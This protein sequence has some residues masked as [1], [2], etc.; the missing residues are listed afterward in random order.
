MLSTVGKKFSRQHIEMFVLF[1]QENM[2]IVSVGGSFY[3]MSKPVFWEKY[4]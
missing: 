4:Y 3:K 2:Q 1:F